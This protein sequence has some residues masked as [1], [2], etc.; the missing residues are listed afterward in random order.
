MSFFDLILDQ[1][2][3]FRIIPVVAIDKV[4]HAVPL[5][6]A[7]LEGGL[8]CAEIT[9]RTEAAEASIKAIAGKVGDFALGAGT[10]LSV[11]HAKRAIGA[12]AS[13]IVAP[14]LN[15]KVVAYCMQEE[16]PVFPGVMTPTEIEQAR[17]L[18]LR[19]LK[20]FPAEQAGG[21]GFLK[22]IG[23]PYKTMKFIPTGGID[24][25]NLLNYLRLPN[26]LACGGS[27]MVKQDLISAGSFGQIRTLTSAAVDVARSVEGAST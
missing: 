19:V 9:F 8:P 22:A 14:G 15:P 11:E 4:E 17:D 6:H 3:S 27:W 16:V 10:V 24:G 20:F 1:I 18:G 5:A 12:G 26:V 21:V 25:S 23:G 7:L 2:A 13:F